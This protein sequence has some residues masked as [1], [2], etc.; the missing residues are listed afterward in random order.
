[1]TLQDFI[2]SISQIFAI[3][4]PGLFGPAGISQDTVPIRNEGMRCGGSAIRQNGILL[5]PVVKVR[6]RVF[7]KVTIA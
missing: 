5:I 1:M 3:A 7:L 4:C 2:D 6:K